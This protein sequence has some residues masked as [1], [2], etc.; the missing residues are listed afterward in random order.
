MI[1][2]KISYYVKILGLIGI[3]GLSSVGV[4]AQ[5]PVKSANPSQSVDPGD[6]RASGYVNDE[7]GL[8]M[9]LPDGVMVLMSDG[10]T[11]ASQRISD[12]L[13]TGEAKN[14]RRLDLVAGKSTVLFKVDSSKPVTYLSIAVGKDSGQELRTSA[15]VTYELLLKTGQ[16]TSASPVEEIKLSG[17]RTFVFALKK[18]NENPPSFFRL[19]AFKRN[20]LLVSI[21]VVYLTDEGLREM[22]SIVKNIRFFKK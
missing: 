16:F 11:G 2:N 15:N 12:S 6:L 1:Q 4:I 5:T 7:L 21:G 3:L 18:I 20:G 19:Y 14:D 10:L 17:L 9:P 13:K 22:E 8:E